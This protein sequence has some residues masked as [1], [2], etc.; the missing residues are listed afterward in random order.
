VLGLGRERKIS[1]FVQLFEWL[2]SGSGAKGVLADVID[3]CTGWNVV[4]VGEGFELG[5]VTVSAMW[6]TSKPVQVRKSG[7]Q[8]N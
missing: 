6:H 8:Q 7:G 2:Y 3:Q 4:D 1:Q 5:G